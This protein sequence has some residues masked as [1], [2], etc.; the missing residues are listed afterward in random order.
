MN[1]RYFELN[2][3]TYW[4]GGGIDLT[5]IYIDKKEAANFHQALKT[6]CGK[7]NPDF[8]PKFKTWADDYFLSHRNET[9]VLGNFL[10][11]SK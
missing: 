7:Y 5:P 2:D 1:V 9:R 3:G 6:I 11:S 8:Y 10:R 4:F